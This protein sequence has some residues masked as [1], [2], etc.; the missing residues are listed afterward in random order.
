MNEQIGNVIREIEIINKEPNGS[1]LELKNTL[2][3]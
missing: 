1:I 2:E 3:M